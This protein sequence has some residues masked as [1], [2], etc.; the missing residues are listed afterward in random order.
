MENKE[1]EKELQEDYRKVKK[2]RKW[3]ARIRLAMVAIVIAFV[4]AMIFVMCNAFNF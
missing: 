2:Y 1:F 4:I 3:A